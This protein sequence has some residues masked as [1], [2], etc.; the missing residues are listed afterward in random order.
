MNGVSP[1]KASRISRMRL[2]FTLVELLVVIAIIVLLAGLLLPALAKSKEKALGT[3]C[4]NHLK[5]LQ[6]CWSMYVHDNDDFLTPNN[7]V[8]TTGGIAISN[9]PTWCAGITRYE[10]NATN[11]ERGLLFQYNRSFA[12]YHCPADQSTVE[13]MAGVKLPIRRNRSYNMNGTL[14]VQ[15]TPWIPT[16]S[17]LAEVI[18]P[19][20][21]QLFVFID[22]D[23]DD[24]YDAHFGIASPLEGAFASFFTNH[25]GDLPADRHN[26]GGNISFADGRVE[27]WR[28]RARKKFVTWGQPVTDESDLADLQRL[29]T[30]IRLRYTE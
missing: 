25:W 6:T 28:W 27:H 2:A 22:T 20:P 5:Q 15:S 23:A 26:V 24:I 29:Q 3:A 10:T 30:G 19:R 17:K 14:G 4:L 1:L 7:D 21:D 11:I 9:G 16:Y 12:I 8:Y 18:R 13:T